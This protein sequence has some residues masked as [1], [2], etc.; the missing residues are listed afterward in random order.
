MK[1]TAQ[2]KLSNSRDSKLPTFRRQSQ[3]GVCVWGGGE[4][5]QISE[6]EAIV[7]LRAYSVSSTS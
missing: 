7:L 5:I 4:E 6:Q 3:N 1:V 2:L